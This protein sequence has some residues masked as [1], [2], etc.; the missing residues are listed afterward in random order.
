MVVQTLSFYSLYIFFFF[1]IHSSFLSISHLYS[2]LPHFLLLRFFF[3]FVSSLPTTFTKYSPKDL[4]SPCWQLWK[5]CETNVSKVTADPLCPTYSSYKLRRKEF[6]P[7]LRNVLGSMIEKVL[8]M[9]QIVISCFFF[10]FSFTYL[11]FEV[12]LLS[13][14]VSTDLQLTRI[15]AGFFSQW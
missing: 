9:S 11:V 2:F 7:F 14:P 4:F 8:Y 12:S 15:C 1:S 13:V 10:F 5:H 3:S 6:Y